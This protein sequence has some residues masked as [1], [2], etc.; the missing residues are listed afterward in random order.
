MASP[1][2][3]VDRRGGKV[4]AFSGSGG[5]RRV[6]AAHAG[7]ADVLPVNHVHQD[8]LD[9]VRGPLGSL[10]GRRRLEDLRGRAGRACGCGR[11]R[12]FRAGFLVRS[13]R[14]LRVDSGTGSSGESDGC[15]RRECGRASARAGSDRGARP[16][17]AM[18][19]KRSTG[20]LAIAFMTIDYRRRFD[21]PCPLAVITP[22]PRRSVR[23]CRPCRSCARAVH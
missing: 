11:R 4:P 16:S 20:S 12:A 9:R 1:V 10:T 5:R 3:G 7:Q 8:L 2:A 18:D 6:L 23:P 13:L 15:R 21:S 22:L 17:S 14:V 19:S